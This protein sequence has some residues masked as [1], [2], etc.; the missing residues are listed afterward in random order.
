MSLVVTQSS[1]LET[2]IGKAVGLAVE[3]AVSVVLKSLQINT[4]EKY[5]SK[6]EAARYLNCSLT[7]IDNYRRKGILKSKKLGGEKKV[8]FLKS[9]LDKIV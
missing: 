4:D 7:T 9:D 1:D 2:L 3:K 6:T 5:L 8:L